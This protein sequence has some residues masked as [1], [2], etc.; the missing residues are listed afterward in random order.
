MI[1]KINNIKTTSQLKFDD[2]IRGQFL[3]G[4]YTHWQDGEPM[5]L[6]QEK[7]NGK[8]ES[9]NYYSIGL[10]SFKTTVNNFDLKKLRT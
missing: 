10:S 3:G 5:F 6:M 8:W 9:L 4:K 7:V 1:H 2:I